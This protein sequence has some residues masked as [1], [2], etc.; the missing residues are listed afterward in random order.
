MNQER[1][2]DAVGRIYY[3]PATGL[4]HAAVLLLAGVLLA[5]TLG[6]ETPLHRSPR[7]VNA[8]E[9]FVCLSLWVEIG[10]RATVVGAAFWASWF[11][12]FDVAVAAASSCCLFWEAPSEEFQFQRREDTELGQSLVMLRIVVQFA[13]VMFIAEHAQRAR[14][15]KLSGSPFEDLGLDFSVLRERGER[16]GL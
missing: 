15:R 10:L 1:L 16:D 5:T 11:N 4:L 6:F 3:S 2:R 12:I 9:A 8:L 13:R 7:L 14:G